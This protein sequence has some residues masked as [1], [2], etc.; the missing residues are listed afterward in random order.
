MKTL[1]LGGYGIC[2]RGITARALCFN[3]SRN[4]KDLTL[5]SLCTRSR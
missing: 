3:E 5:S 2:P 4:M 1:L